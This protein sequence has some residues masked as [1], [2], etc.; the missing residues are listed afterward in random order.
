MPG[1]IPPRFEGQ[2]RPPQP[3]KREGSFGLDKAHVAAQEVIERQAIDPRELGGPYNQK[4]VFADIQYA[5]DM[6]K[7]FE[8]DSDERVRTA[9]K[10]SKIMEVALY[11]QV[12]KGWFGSNAHAVLPSKYDD[13]KNKVDLITEFEITEANVSAHAQI[14]MG[15]DVT[16]SHDLKRK[17][18]DIQGDIDSGQLT[19]VKYYK[20]PDGHMVG[21]LPKVPRVVVGM[22]EQSALVVARAWYE[23]NPALKTDP[24]RDKVLIQ[25]IDQCEAFE[26]YAHTKGNQEAAKSYARAKT[27]FQKAYGQEVTPEKRK[28][29][30]NDK[31]LQ[32]L[33]LLIHQLQ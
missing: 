20:S 28:K 15:I 32:T 13:I 5:R 21:S 16:Y 27:L 22:D 33:E 24:L 10:L 19:T 4:D 23:K 9:R 6:E 17:I 14:P 7:K 25:V 26:R 3:E 29:F 30:I 31:V 2:F 11:E 8:Q 18:H 1:L 12:N